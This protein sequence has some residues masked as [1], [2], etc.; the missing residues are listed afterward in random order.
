MSG[1]AISRTTFQAEAAFFEDALTTQ[2][3]PASGPTLPAAPLGR[4]AVATCF[5]VQPSCLAVWSRLAITQGPLISDP[6]LPFTK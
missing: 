4:T 1:C 5:A 2:L 6:V 3:P